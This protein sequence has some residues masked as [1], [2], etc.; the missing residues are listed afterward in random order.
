MV[1]ALRLID[2]LTYYVYHKDSYDERFR[3]LALIAWNLTSSKWMI[4]Q[5]API[6]ASF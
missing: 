1:C 5:L 6:Y 2:D 4:P 3:G